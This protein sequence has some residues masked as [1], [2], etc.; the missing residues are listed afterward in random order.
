[1]YEEY[2]QVWFDDNK[3]ED[4][5]KAQLLEKSL[6]IVTLEKV[7]YEDWFKRFERLESIIQLVEERTPK[8]Q[9]DYVEQKINRMFN[10]IFFE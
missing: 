10:S 4:K 3:L 5:K 9:E 1:M 6:E 7:K 2:R 8:G